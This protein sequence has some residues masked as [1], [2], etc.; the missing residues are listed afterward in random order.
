MKPTIKLIGTLLIAACLFSACDTG[1]GGTNGTTN[2]WRSNALTQ[3]GLKGSVQSMTANSSVSNFNAAGNLSSQTS[4]NSQS[5]TTYTYEGGFLVSATSSYGEGQPSTITYEYNNTGKYIPK[6]PFHLY[7]TGLVPA[8][9][10]V[11]A[12]NYRSDYTF[13]GN[14]LWIVNSM[15]EGTVVTPSDTT[16]MHYSG[17]YLSSYTGRYD[18]LENLTYADNGMFRTYSEGFYGV[19][20]RDT[21]T[22]TFVNTTERMLVATQTSTNTSQNNSSSG[23]ITYTYNSHLDLLT[24]VDNSSS[25]YNNEVME[26]SSEQEYS[27]YVYD[28]HGNWTSRKYR[29]KYNQQG[30]SDYQT[31]TRSFVY[32]N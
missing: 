3:L 26:Y 16:I 32:Y 11:I 5:S 9:S 23:L 17:N 10:A 13:H 14:D 25:T 24:V 28:S 30:W 18:F 4:T 27:D 20:Y 2:Y 21:R 31:E 19:G 8:L 1:T 22:Y 15:I 12:E 29:N 7:M 6:N